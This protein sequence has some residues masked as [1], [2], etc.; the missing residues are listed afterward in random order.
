MQAFYTAVERHLGV[1]PALLAAHEYA[2]LAA[3]GFNLTLSAAQ[4]AP[5]VAQMRLDLYGGLPP[6]EYGDKALRWGIQARTRMS[7]E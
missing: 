6:P 2:V 5:H 3:L 7:W 4:T 1:S